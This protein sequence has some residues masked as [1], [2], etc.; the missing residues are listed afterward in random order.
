MTVEQR[1]PVAKSVVDSLRGISQRYLGESSPNIRRVSSETLLIISKGPTIH[2]H[3]GHRLAVSART[4]DV[5]S[6]FGDEVIRK[7]IAYGDE[8]VTT[9]RNH[10][11]EAERQ[12]LLDRLTFSRPDQD[13]PSHPTLL[14]NLSI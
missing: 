3:P 1:T 13:L 6:F 9:Q 5:Y 12:E 4:T 10:V 11:D 2:T 7:T 14:A 8:D